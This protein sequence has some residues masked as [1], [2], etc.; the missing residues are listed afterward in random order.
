MIE[1]GVILVLLVLAGLALFFVQ[2]YI[3]ETRHQIDSLSSEIKRLKKDNEELTKERDNLR[4]Y[5]FQSIYSTLIPLGQ[6]LKEIGHIIITSKEDLTDIIFQIIGYDELEQHKV[7]YINGP[8]VQGV[9][10]GRVKWRFIHRISV[11][12]KSFE[13]NPRTTNITTKTTEA[14]E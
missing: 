8:A 9:A 2:K 13:F 3:K 5:N 12:K 4:Q 10:L 11:A 7:E 1:Y 14:K 6:C